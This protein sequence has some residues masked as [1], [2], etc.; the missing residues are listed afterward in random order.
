MADTH[1][2]ICIH[3]CNLL[4]LL[5]NTLITVI[6]VGKC[7]EKTGLPFHNEQR[8]VLL[9]KVVSSLPYL[10]VYLGAGWSNVPVMPFCFFSMAF[11]PC[12][13]STLCV[14]GQHPHHP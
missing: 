5:K 4:P 10:H 8:Q 12:L 2:L 13:L 7:T 6:F 14:V 9:V 11:K 1:S 3:K